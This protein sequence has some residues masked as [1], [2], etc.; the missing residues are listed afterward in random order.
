MCVAIRKVKSCAKA[1]RGDTLGLR[2]PD[3]AK[4][5]RPLDSSRPKFLV[6][7]IF[8]GSGCCVGGYGKIVGFW[9]HE[10]RENPLG[11]ASI[12]LGFIPDFT[13]CFASGLAACGRWAR[14]DKVGKRK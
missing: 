5:L 11:Y 4:G 1:N 8:S 10:I 13:G 9:P 7:S 6:W 2:A 12:P 3:C 14:S